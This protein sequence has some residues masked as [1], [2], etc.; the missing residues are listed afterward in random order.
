MNEFRTVFNIPDFPEQITYRKKSLFTGS[1]FTEYIGKLMKDHKFP[2]LVNP[3]GVI[4]NPVSAGKGLELLMGQIELGK[5]DYLNFNGLWH[6]FYH[7]SRFSNP[8]KEKFLAGILDGLEKSRQF[9]ENSRFLIITFGTAFVYRYKK[10]GKI[11]SNCHKI[12]TVEFQREMLG[13]EGIINYYHNLLN[14]LFELNPQLNIVFTVSP[15]RHLKDG[16]IDNQAS[17]ATLILSVR[18]LCKSFKNALYFPAYEIVMDDLRD[19][20][21]YDEDMVHPNS[22]AIKYI[23]RLFS[24][25]LISPD[26]IKISKEINKIRK[27]FTHRPFNKKSPQ[28]H[29]FVENNLNKI[30]SMKAKLPF[31]DFSEEEDYFKN[32]S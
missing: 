26:D 2:V 6:S 8:D 5:N 19:Y 29:Q 31:L 27:A 16:A 11:V 32:F 24:E 15:V 4:Y 10:T 14:R 28:F 18:E 7:H 25:S 3:F 30:S 20:R 17:K 1:C 21:F 13:I 22:Q 23:Y 9:L 12:P